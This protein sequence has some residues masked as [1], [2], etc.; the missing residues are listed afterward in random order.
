MVDRDEPRF[1]PAPEPSKPDPLPPEPSFDPELIP[2]PPSDRPET[3]APGPGTPPDLDELIPQEGEQEPWYGRDRMVPGFDSSRAR[4]ARRLGRTVPFWWLIGALLLGIVVIAFVFSRADSTP[5]QE[6]PALE[7]SPEAA[8]PMEALSEEQAPA[9]APVV[10]VQ[11]TPV[12]TP[13]PV[14]AVGQQVVV[15]NTDGEG[16]RLRSAPGLGSLTL[17]IYEEGRLFQILE[18]GPEY[19]TYP[20]EAD[21]YRW[22]RVQVADDPEDQLS[23]WVAGEFLAPPP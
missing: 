14:F 23:G 7:T 1:D 9:T 11:P 10:E 20:V 21:G 3:P 19:P 22:Y 15:A 16:I 18:P 17:E 8:T 12:P 4:R 2:H 5:S 6:T 13:I